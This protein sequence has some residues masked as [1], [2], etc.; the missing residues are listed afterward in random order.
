MTTQTIEVEG[1]PEGREI[2]LV[3]IMP[4]GFGDK[5]GNN[6]IATVKLKEIQPLR[7]VLEE[8]EEERSISFGDWYEDDVGNV[9]RYLNMHFGSRRT[10]KIWREVN[11]TDI[12][13]V[14]DEPKLSLSVR[15]CKALFT[16]NWPLIRKIREFIKENS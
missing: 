3:E 7:I 12:P 10:Y 1:L 14:N 15:E 9:S 13:L 11:E 8:T 4:S 16:G 6:L 2:E 5:S